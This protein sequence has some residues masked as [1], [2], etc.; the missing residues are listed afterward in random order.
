MLCWTRFRESIDLIFDGAL[1]FSLLIVIEEKASRRVL[2][3][4]KKSV[5]HPLA[6]FNAIPKSEIR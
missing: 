3:S 6:L 2:R 5:H 4:I 1:H